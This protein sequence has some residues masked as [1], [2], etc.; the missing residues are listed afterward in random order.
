MKQN[1]KIEANKS[2]TKKQAELGPLDCPVSAEKAAATK[3]LRSKPDARACV[4]VGDYTWA[5]V[6][7]S[8]KHIKRFKGIVR[9]FFRDPNNLTGE[10]EQRWFHIRERGDLDGWNANAENVD[11]YVPWKIVRVA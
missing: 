10:S 1:K 4:K 11:D 7:G 5:K 6:I 9:L 3:A 2:E 8:E